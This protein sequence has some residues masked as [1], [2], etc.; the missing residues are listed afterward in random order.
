MKIELFRKI[1]EEVRDYSR[2]IYFHV[3]GEPLM[4]PEIESFL[5]LCQEYGCFANITTNATLLGNIKDKIISKKALRLINFS[6]HSFES[7]TPECEID[8][9]LDGILSFVKE[10]KKNNPEIISCFRL[11]N[12][13][14]N[15]TNFSN[16][17]VLRKIEKFFRV[18]AEIKEI[19]ATSA[20][21]GIKVAHNTYVN[22]AECF[23]WPNA[24]IPDLNLKGFCLGLRDQAA[25]LVDGTVVPCCVDSEGVV[26]LGNIREI[27][28]SEIING[29]RA[30][31]LYDGFSARKL[32]ESLCRKCGYRSRFK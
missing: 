32:V 10:A 9:Y 14:E 8:S 23:D 29:K 25:I 1:L 13:K 12:M 16:Q 24:N 15:S 19:P 30:V 21:N 7:N 3:M 17:Y 11:W 18:S 28:F 27:S 4:H 22:Q 5:D 26:N 31:D 2:Y 20:S 6:L